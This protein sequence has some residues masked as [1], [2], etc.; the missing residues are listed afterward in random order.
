ML[1]RD[2]DVMIGPGRGVC[3]SP[4][5]HFTTA[6]LGTV[7]KQV[8]IGLYAQSLCAYCGRFVEESMR[9]IDHKMP[10]SR[11]GLHS[12]SN[13]AMACFSCNSSK[14]ARADT[15]FMEARNGL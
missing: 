8:V 7:T 15:E 13:L 4:P 6:T 10:L 9:T 2:F 5:D 1:E 3:T 14:A 12:A 11:G